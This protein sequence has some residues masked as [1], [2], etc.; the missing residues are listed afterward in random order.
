[1]GKQPALLLEVMDKDDGG[2]GGRRRRRVRGV[3]GVVGDGGSSS[4][5]TW[6]IPGVTILTPILPELLTR[7]HSQISH[8][9]HVT[10]DCIVSHTAFLYKF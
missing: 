2:G 10:R 8:L 6:L 7:I 9:S 5:S 3:G 1:M 4:S